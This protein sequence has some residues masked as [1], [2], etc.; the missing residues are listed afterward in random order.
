MPVIHIN[1]TDDYTRVKNAKASIIKYSTKWCGPCKRIAPAFDNLSSRYPHILFASVD[2]ENT[3]TPESAG[4]AS[5]PTF[6][7]FM[8]GVITGKFTGADINQVEIL[9]MRT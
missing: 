7:L 5:V 1:T 4:I 3:P 2:I 6:I 8:N 9:A